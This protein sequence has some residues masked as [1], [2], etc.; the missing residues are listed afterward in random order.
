MLSLFGG[1]IQ[2]VPIYRMGCTMGFSSVSKAYSAMFGMRG[3]QA[4][5]F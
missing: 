3:E 4:Y 2:K 5:V 1:L